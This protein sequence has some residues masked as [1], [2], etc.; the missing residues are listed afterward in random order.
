MSTLQQPPAHLAPLP[1]GRVLLRGGVLAGASADDDG[2]GGVPSALVLDGSTVAWVGDEEG[3]AA[4]ADRVDRVVDL[5]GLLVTPG[6]ADA[7]VHLTM[8]GQGLDGVD[9]SGTRSVGEALDLVE[10]AVRR[11]RGRPVYAHSWDETRWAEGRP[12]TSAELD[13][14]SYGGVVY[15]PR[16]DAHS[17]SVST[18]MATIARVR[19]ID[20]W[21]GTGVVRRDAFAAATNA[22]TTTLTPADREHHVSL[23]L[24]AAAAVGV[25][26]LHEM[27]ASHLTSHDDIRDVLAHG[28]GAGVPDVVAYWGELAVDAEAAAELAGFLGVLG[29]AGDLCADGSF[30]SFTAHVEQPYLGSPSGGREDGHHVG[31]GYLGVDE[32]RDHVLACTRAGLQAGG[33]VIG[34]AALRTMATGFR[35]AADE[36][37]VEAVRAARHRWEHVELPSPRVLATMA[38]LGVWASVQPVFDALWGGSGGMYAARLGPERA[39]AA[40]PLRDMV[41]AGVRLA[42]GSDSPVTPLGPWAAV[43]AAVLHHN[44]DQ[45]LTPAEAFAAHTVAGH[46]L[47]GR[48]GGHLRAGAHATYVVWDDGDGAPVAT[49]PTT[50]LPVL[51]DP[52]LP[53]P[54]ARLTVVSGQVAHDREG[55]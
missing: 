54:V 37:G 48:P 55:A 28:E 44:P 11:R 36:L 30:G 49:D 53:L 32:V 17:A 27:G 51:D 4:W 24:D 1:G 45:R 29:L 2:T 12:V 8:T 33:H 18:A 25:T 47:A 41:D 9:L 52:D 6:F 19:D 42:F 38:E 15:M 43:R 14:A 10:Q 23:A 7:H 13:R 39:L 50:G 21:D 5:G 46:E 34:D 40:L 22:F 35:A 20:G 31:F 3:A 16:V 26:L